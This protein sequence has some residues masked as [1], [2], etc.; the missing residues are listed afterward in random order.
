MVY[1]GKIKRKVVTEQEDI[2][3][4]NVCINLLPCLE[5]LGNSS[6]KG[7]F[8]KN[9]CKNFNKQTQSNRAVRQIRNRFKSMYEYYLKLKKSNFFESHELKSENLTEEDVF[10]QALLE[11]FSQIYYDERGILNHRVQKTE[12]IEYKTKTMSS[13]LDEL[14]SKSKDNTQ[15]NYTTDSIVNNMN[16]NVPNE[17]SFDLLDVFYDGVT[18]GYKINGDDMFNR[19]MQLSPVSNILT[20]T[21]YKNNK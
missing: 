21:K 20:N 1:H 19:K 8:W 9:V 6:Y 12:K 4:L 18:Y 17:A 13:T 14:L 16:S 7:V 11:C 3:L 10:F 5:S 15:N 2:I